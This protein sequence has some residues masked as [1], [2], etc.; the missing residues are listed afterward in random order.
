[1]SNLKLESQFYTFAESSQDPI[2]GAMLV[3]QVIDEETDVLWIEN[4]LERLAAGLAKSKCDAAGL[5]SYLRRLGFAGADNYFRRENSS[6]NFVLRRRK[7][8]PITLAMLLMGV[9]RLVGLEVEGIN[10]PGHFLARIEGSLVDPFELKA[11]ELDDNLVSLGNDITGSSKLSV[12]SG[13]DIVMRMFN[14]LRQ[15]A[16]E[17]GDYNAALDYC[18]Y[19][20]ILAERPFS[21]YVERVSL[22][23][24]AGVKEMALYDLEKSIVHAPNAAVRT[25]LEEHRTRIESSPS[26]LH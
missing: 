10:Y 3:S 19:Q 26:K 11:F 20:L 7:G 4:E 13:R 21:V 24:A 15:I 6:L 18:G 12:A 14:N 16:S 23:L 1:M 9:G 22:W 5:S 17:E 2:A 8:I 25:K